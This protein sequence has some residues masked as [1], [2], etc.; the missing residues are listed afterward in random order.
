MWYGCQLMRQLSN[1]DKMTR[2]SA[3]KGCSTA[4]NNEQTGTNISNSYTL[5][6]FLEILH[7]SQF[8]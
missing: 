5:P 7:F 8:C 3:T 1:R 6:K 4:L 2:I